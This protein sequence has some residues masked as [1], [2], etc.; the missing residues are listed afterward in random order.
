MKVGM[1]DK[2]TD[3]FQPQQD[4]IMHIKSVLPEVVI[5]AGGPPFSLYAEAMMRR[6]P[7][8]DLGVW[9]EA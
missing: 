3:D 1:P 8:I 2:Y 5:I 4:T 9:G 6:V 7:A